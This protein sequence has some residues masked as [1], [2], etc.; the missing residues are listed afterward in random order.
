MGEAVACDDNGVASFDLIRH[1]RHNDRAFL[2][3][4]DL[5]PDRFRPCLQD[6]ARRHRVKAEGLDVSLRALA[7]LADD[8]EPSGSGGEAGSG[9]GLE[10]EHGRI[11][12]IFPSLV[13][14]LQ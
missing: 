5:I 13:R 9:G 6:G 2:Y 7:R 10:L 4:I 8:E 11:S 12:T 1:H 3:A 14:H